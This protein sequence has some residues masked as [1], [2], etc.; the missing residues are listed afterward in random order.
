MAFNQINFTLNGHEMKLICDENLY[1]CNN[2]LNFIDIF[3]L[4]IKISYT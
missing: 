3:Q 4:S 2:A 1:V